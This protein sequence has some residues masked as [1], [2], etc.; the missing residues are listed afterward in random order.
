MCSGHCEYGYI[1]VGL[2]RSFRRSFKKGFLSQRLFSDQS[3]FP[4]WLQASEHFD[5]LAGFG[6]G[7]SV[8]WGQETNFTF[9]GIFFPTHLAASLSQAS[10]L[11]SQPGLSL[12][13]A[14]IALACQY[15]KRRSGHGVCFLNPVSGDQALSKPFVGLQT[16]AAVA[17]ASL[18]LSWGQW[19][20]AFCGEMIVSLG[21]VEV[22]GC[23]LCLN[24]KLWFRF[25]FFSKSV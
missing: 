5:P 21:R 13:F 17:C 10:I 23:M 2:D 19:C 4:A 16:G 3:L 7:A 20:W 18:S 15:L 24:S 9:W 6:D 11:G 12:S 8:A 25:M 1:T 14:L 22:L